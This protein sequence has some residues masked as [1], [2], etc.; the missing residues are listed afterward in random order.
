[1]RKNHTVILII[2]DGWGIGN[3]DFSNPIHIVNPK[4]IN[5]L[6]ENF[7]S[8]ALQASGISVG[9]PW[10]EEGNSEVGHLNMGA[11]KIIYQNYPKI[12]LAIR[13]K[14]FFENKAIKDAF[15]HAKKNNSS[16]NLIGLLTEAN[17]HAS[18]EHLEA[19]IQFFGKEG[20]PKEKLNLHLITDGRDSPPQSAIALLKKISH[21]ERIASVSGRY[22]AMDR[23]NHWDRTEEA[24]K[25]MTGDAP[26][27][28]DIET[29]IKKT[30]AKNLND[31]FIAPA[32][33]SSANPVKDNDAIIFFNFREDRMKQIVKSFIDS[34]FD[35]F[36][37]KKFSNLRATTLVNYDSKFNLPIAFPR[38]KIDGC[39]G[40][41]LSEKG[42]I[43]WRIAET[44]KY[45]HI[46]YFFNGLKEQPFLNEYRVLIPSQTN[47][48]HDEHPEMRA[49]EIASRLIE[50]IEEKAYDFILANFANAD[51]IAHT[52]NFEATKKTIEVLNEQIG[53]IT[54]TAL[55]SDAYLIITA[56][57]GNAERL[58]DP[59]TGMPE[60]KHD[61]SSV[62]IYLVGNEFKRKKTAEEIRRS[63]KN[64]IGVLADISPTVLELM[65][66]AKPKEMTAQSL[67][68]LL[69]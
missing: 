5:Y 61:A 63:E 45:A 36:K 17:V 27:M 57:H 3:P 40:K 53:K 26:A 58:L 65:G 25:A 10:G 18:F 55:D 49:E 69:L 35:K 11:G 14:T 28:T 31:E 62:P 30:Y 12:T 22:Y 41:V 48:K 37:T 24:Y 21:I 2:L 46:T 16:V 54:K 23:D 34:E 42:K 38:E 19:L 43:Q 33:V 52:G 20:L 39:L 9:L 64:P 47:F 4:N 29:H 59:Q 7:P 50:A 15:V 60:T 6:K 44:E 56:D 67:L 13:D 8:G 32:F 66:I 1:M 68:N 51:I